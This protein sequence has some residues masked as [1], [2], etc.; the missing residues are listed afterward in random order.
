[1]SLVMIQ[2]LVRN[3]IQ[4]DWQLASGDCFELVLDTKNT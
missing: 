2:E 3:R 4:A 1:M